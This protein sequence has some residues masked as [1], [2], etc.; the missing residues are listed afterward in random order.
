MQALALVL[1]ALATFRVTRLVTA[2]AFPPVA[3]LRDRVDERWGDVSWQAYL[4]TCPWC[5]SVYAAG[6]LTLAAVL[7]LD[8]GL[9]APLLAWPAA[10][11]ATGLLASLDA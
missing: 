10:S 8:D 9:P 7:L 3:A 11:A 2:D 5:V 4:V 1:L 6:A